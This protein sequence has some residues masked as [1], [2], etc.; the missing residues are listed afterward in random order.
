[1]SLDEYMSDDVADMPPP[2][3]GGNGGPDPSVP[4]DP[5]TKPSALA[6]LGGDAIR[7]LSGPG[8]GGGAGL[9]HS[10]MVPVPPMQNGQGYDP[11]PW[12]RE[13]SEMAD[14]R[15]ATSRARDEALRRS[16]QSWGERINET[17]SG[18]LGLGGREE[19]YTGSISD[20]KLFNDLRRSGYSAGEAEA[21]L[22][23]RNKRDRYADLQKQGFTRE[24]ARQLINRRSERELAKRKGQTAMQGKFTEDIRKAEERYADMGRIE[25]P[26]DFGRGKV[27]PSGFT[28]DQ[29]RQ[30]VKAGTFIDHNKDGR[31]DK[32]DDE[33]LASE[34]AA[35][36]ITIP[37]D[38]GTVM[39]DPGTVFGD[40]GTVPGDEG[41]QRVTPVPG[42]G[43]PIRGSRGQILK[44]ETLRSPVDATAT[45]ADGM[46]TALKEPM[47]L[48]DE[49][50]RTE[51]LRYG[52][53]HPDRPAGE[54]Q[55]DRLAAGASLR[56]GAG[57][58]SGPRDLVNLG[59]DGARWADLTQEQKK[60]ALELARPTAGGEDKPP[61]RTPMQDRR[62]KE[63]DDTE[64]ARKGKAPTRPRVPIGEK[65]Y[66]SD[67]PDL[68]IGDPDFGPMT[69]LKKE[70]SLRPT[71][72]RVPIGETGYGSD[73][74]DLDID[75]P[76]FGDL[77]APPPKVTRRRSAV[78]AHF[79]GADFPNWDRNNPGEINQDALRGSIPGFDEMSTE[80]QELAL[81][82]AESMFLWSKISG[83]PLSPVAKRMRKYFQAMKHGDK[84]AQKKALKAV[85]PHNENARK[86][87][88]ARWAAMVR[89]RAISQAQLK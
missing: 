77:A 13:G 74:P 72:P 34:I 79:A 2:R 15:G 53:G 38:P 25:L 39:G 67:D 61:N 54:R 80:D 46:L 37:G 19:E 16:R 51:R 87:A 18:A 78:N 40:P 41:Y 20:G 66:G 69:N 55:V 86:L 52:S 63:E 42:S 44:Q 58:V 6:P 24:E 47:A 17:F 4:G 30:R 3:N 71:R 32:A 48:A 49:K 81:A 5:Q 75:D 68:D 73:D 83:G 85:H 29:I 14:T 84:K 8:G 82:Q 1:M 28:P 26:D 64:R 89:T 9:H 60:E 70:S 56:R 59:G 11:Q 35:R 22:A 50:W 57:S 27:G 31:I 33:Y 76:D 65:D 36:E 43:E 23:F 12:L 10:E 45:D 21:A 7:N 88:E 62:R